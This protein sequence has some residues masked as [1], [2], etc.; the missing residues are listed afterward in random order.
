MVGIDEQEAPIVHGQ[1]LAAKAWWGRGV[2]IVGDPKLCKDRSLNLSAVK[3]CV[4]SSARAA[5]GMDRARR[6]HAM[7]RR[8]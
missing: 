7:A 8:C 5:A 4:I 3:G 6:A 1:P 2:L